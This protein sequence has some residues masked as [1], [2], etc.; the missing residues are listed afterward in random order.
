VSCPMAR[1]ASSEPQQ[2]GTAVLET[3]WSA[4]PTRLVAPRETVHV[5]RASLDP[6]AHHVSRLHDVLSDSE[7]IRAG[8]YSFERDRTRSIAARGLL[9]VILGRYLT[10]PPGDLR[11]H[12]GVTGKPMLSV[13]QARAIEFSVSHSHGLVVYAVTCDRR[14]GIDIE[15][16]RAVASWAGLAG[17]VLS[18]GEH[19]VFR[20]L[21]PD[22]QRAAFFRAWTR[23]EACVKAWGQGL[24]CPLDRIDLSLEPGGPL[25]I[26]GDGGASARWSLQ[27]LDPAPGY[28]GAL[29]VEGG[30][31]LPLSRM[32]WPAWL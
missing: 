3:E 23:K 4:P 1:P 7:R 27:D 28:A 17:R 18:P 6:P 24:S 22:Q 2:S 5:W 8:Q 13:S 15:R 26:H 16:V 19:A 11:I 29:A 20:A 25:S 12:S 14:I 31:V 30:D 10:I 21:P 32:Q 9:R